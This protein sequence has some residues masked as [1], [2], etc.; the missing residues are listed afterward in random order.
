MH[1]NVDIHNAT[2]LYTLEM[3]NVIHFALCIFYHNFFLNC[4]MRKNRVVEFDNL[5]IGRDF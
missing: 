2:E 3:V 5:W 4:S 1:N